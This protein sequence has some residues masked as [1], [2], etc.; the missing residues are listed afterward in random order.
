MSFR[1][2]ICKRIY[3]DHKKIPY[4]Q[5]V[6]CK[7]FLILRILMQEY[8][9]NVDVIKLASCFSNISKPSDFPLANA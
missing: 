6:I 3:A 5:I 8:M 1:L 9:R 7:K 2:K 4:K